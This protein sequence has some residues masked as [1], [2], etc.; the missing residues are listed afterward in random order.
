MYP[1]AAGARWCSAEVVLEPPDA[2]RVRR[3]PARDLESFELRE[4]GELARVEAVDLDI[5]Q[6]AVPHE[7]Q[8]ADEVASGIVAN[9]LDGDEIFDNRGREPSV[10]EQP[11]R[12]APAG[13]RRTGC[14]SC[15]G[16]PSKLISTGE[17]FSKE[18]LENCAL[19]VREW[20]GGHPMRG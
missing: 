12:G 6:V 17:R 2:I 11:E 13:A 5:V 19:L 3:V 10:C 20:R 16:L 7:E 14:A 9:G 15:F 4:P 1:P 18:K 8:D